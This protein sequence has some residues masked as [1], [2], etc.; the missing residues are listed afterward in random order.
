MCGVIGDRTRSRME[1]P[2][3]GDLGVRRPVRPDRGAFS[4]ALSIFIAADTT[5]LNWC[6]PRS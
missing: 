1:K 3:S 2:S 6:L 4:R 5:V